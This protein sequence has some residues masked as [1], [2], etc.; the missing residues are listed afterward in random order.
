MNKLLLFQL[1]ALFVVT[2]L[3]GLHVA[4]NLIEQGV[5]A[6]I[7]TDNP[8]DIENAV[9]LI[10]YILV[11]TAIVLVAITFFK[12]RFFGVFLRLFEIGAVFGTS[13]I[14]LSPF[15]GGTAFMFAVLIIAARLALK[16]NIWLKNATS[17]LAV[18][19]VG[20]VLGVSLGILPVLVF[21]SVLALY[22]I[23]AV[24]GTK[25]M[26]KMAQAITS[27]NLA[28]T[29]TLPTKKHAF[30]L[31]TGD[32]VIPL[33]FATAALKYSALRVEFPAFFLPSLAVLVA[34][35]LG[36][37]LT[38]EYCAKKRIALPALPLQTLF[39]VAAWLT[40]WLFFVG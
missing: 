32:M 26:V 6:H 34:S 25:H 19:G 40:M 30:Q 28:F 17:V 15:L 23:I 27:Q 36:L 14:V 13:M 4:S 22:D 39:M 20:S 31:G 16:E 7:V 2:Q 8:E 12:P 10:I 1:V 3:L 11:V 37:L 24:F 9:G 21:I 35:L 29:F 33:V 18:A 5:E 38:L